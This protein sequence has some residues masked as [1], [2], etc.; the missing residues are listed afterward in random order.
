M[1][2]KCAV[3]PDGRI[4]GEVLK[5]GTEA[6]CDAI[7]NTRGGHDVTIITREPLPDASEVYVWSLEVIK[8]PGKNFNPANQ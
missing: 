4:F 2:I 6:E 7:F 3:T 1:A 5:R 8:R